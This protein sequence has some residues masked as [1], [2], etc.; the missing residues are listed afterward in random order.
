M[1][2]LFKPAVLKL[3]ACRAANIDPMSMP[4]PYK[5]PLFATKGRRPF[6]VYQGWGYIRMGE[7]LATLLGDGSQMAILISAMLAYGQSASSLG[8]L[9]TLVSLGASILLSAVTVI[10]EQVRMGVVVPRAAFPH[11]RRR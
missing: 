4:L 9:P 7:A 5:S 10:S 11:V 8:I 1:L 2:A 3:L 6:D